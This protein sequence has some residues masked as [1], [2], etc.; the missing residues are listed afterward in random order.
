MLDVAFAGWDIHWLDV[1]ADVLVYHIDDR[2]HCYRF[3]ASDV[4][5]LAF[6]LFDSCSK[7]VCLDDVIDIGE[8]PALLSV[9]VNRRLF[10]FQ[11]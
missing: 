4:G 6:G 10:I 1:F 8:V 7:Q 9:A 11:D 3:S 5:N 2:I